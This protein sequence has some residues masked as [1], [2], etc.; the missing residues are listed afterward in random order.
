[1]DHPKQQIYFHI[2]AS[3]NPFFLILYTLEISHHYQIYEDFKFF[4]DSVVVEYFGSK[5]PKKK[6]KLKIS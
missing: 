5:I 4:F 3:M 1:M 6:L 2:F